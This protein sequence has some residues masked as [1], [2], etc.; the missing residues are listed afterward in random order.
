M[1]DTPHELAT[2]TVRRQAAREITPEQM[3]QRIEALRREFEN[4]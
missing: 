2:W 1:T 3:Q 4:R